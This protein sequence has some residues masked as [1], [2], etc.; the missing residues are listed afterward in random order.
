MR[1]Y[2]N[3]DEIIEA[4]SNNDKEAI[5]QGISETRPIV[6]INALIFGTKLKLKDKIFVEAVSKLRDSGNSFFGVPMYKYAVA[7]LDVLD[8]EKYKETDEFIQRLIKSGFD[9]V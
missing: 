1:K 2:H 7:A 8:A 4:I 3:T 6:Q 9:L 5:I